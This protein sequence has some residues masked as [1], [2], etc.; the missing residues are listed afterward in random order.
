MPFDSTR[1]ADFRDAN[2]APKRR[3]ETG[4]PRVNPEAPLTPAE[5]ARRHRQKH[6]ARIN[7]TRRQRRKVAAIMAGVSPEAHAHQR[8]IRNQHAMA[9]P[10][11]VAAALTGYSVEVL[12]RA[13]AAPFI[14]RHEWLGTVGRATIF[15][16]LFS[17]QRDLQGVAAFGDGPATA[18]ALI[19]EPALCLQRGACSH[20]APKNAATF[21]ITRA[22]KLVYRNHGISRFIAYADPCAGEYG[23]VYQAA[24]WAYLGQGL[25]GE[26]RYRTHRSAV[27]PPG[28]DRATRRSG[29]PTATSDAMDAP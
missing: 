7:R 12:D 20:R 11:E 6:A 3:N 13:V 8:R 4:R 16:G 25:R 15:V 10:A 21:L 27:L 17:P 1:N 19:G 18:A 5:R 22:C 24:G 23:A 9:D 26:G 29:G 2:E 14:K 28:A